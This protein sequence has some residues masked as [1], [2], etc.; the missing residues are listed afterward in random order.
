MRNPVPDPVNTEEE[1]LTAVERERDTVSPALTA[2]L[3]ADRPATVAQVQ[4]AVAFTRRVEDWYLY[5]LGPAKAL[6]LGRLV[7]RLNEVLAEIRTS[8]GTCEA[9]LLKRIAAQQ[10]VFDSQPPPAPPAPP[11]DPVAAH[12]DALA[13][14]MAVWEQR[15]KEQ[16]AQFDAW[17]EQHRKQQA[18]YDARNKAWSD[19]F[20]KH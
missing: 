6:G 11:P 5:M 4:A 8:R 10:A 18:E 9:M 12:R 3:P 7:Q 15:R 1:W 17:Q 13:K 14:Q 2:M 19:G 20:S 16:Q